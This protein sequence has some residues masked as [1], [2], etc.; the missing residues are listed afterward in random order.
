[1]EPRIA[2]AGPVFAAVLI[3]VCRSDFLSQELSRCGL[4]NCS[5]KVPCIFHLLTSAPGPLCFLFKTSWDT[6]LG[7]LRAVSLQMAP[8]RKPLMAQVDLSQCVPP[9]QC[10]LLHRKHTPHLTSS[11]TL[12]SFA[13][14]SQCLGSMHGAHCGATRDKPSLIGTVS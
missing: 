12:A 1:M 8:P 3:S 5:T 2:L 4:W 13:L 6:I 11:Y 7:H 10:F 9:P 14:G